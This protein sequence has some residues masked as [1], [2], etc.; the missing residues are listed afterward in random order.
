[1]DL[2]FYLDPE[3]GQAHIRLH[4]VTELE[5][6]QVLERPIEDRAG[7]EG[8]RVTIGQTRGGRY[9]RVIY[10]TDSGPNSVFIIT[11]YELGGKPLDAFRRRRRKKHS[12]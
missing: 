9:L 3:T 11:A 5:V 12:P 6:E 4:G 2:R 10:V 8:S 1:V 7:R